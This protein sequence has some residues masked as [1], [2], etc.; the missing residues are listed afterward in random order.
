MYVKV[1]VDDKILMIT[2]IQILV[3]K[4]K[5]RLKTLERVRNKCDFKLGFEFGKSSVFLNVA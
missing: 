3:T 2:L 1:V 4:A 5:G